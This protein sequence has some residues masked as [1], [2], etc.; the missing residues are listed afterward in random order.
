MNIPRL[1]NLALFIEEDTGNK[2]NMGTWETCICGFA[3]RAFF[4]RPLRKNVLDSVDKVAN[5]LELNS[6]QADML[7][8]W[9][10]I[11][12]GD[13]LPTRDEAVQAIREM[14]LTGKPSWREVRHGVLINAS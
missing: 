9:P 4:R 5:Y 14:I 13:R 12:R 1:S 10:I 8:R 7:F 2:F 11:Y 3:H 6:E